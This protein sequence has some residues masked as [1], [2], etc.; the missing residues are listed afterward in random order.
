VFA[1]LKYVSFFNFVLFIFSFG[2][3]KFVLQCSFLEILIM[4]IMI[5]VMMMIISINIL[6]LPLDL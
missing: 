6:G 1:L 2:C 5:L 3:C 4:I